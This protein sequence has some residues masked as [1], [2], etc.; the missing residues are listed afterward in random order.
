[1]ANCPS[2][3][4]SQNAAR[5]GSQFDSS[6]TAPAPAERKSVHSSSMLFYLLRFASLDAAPR[7]TPAI[8]LLSATNVPLFKAHCCFLI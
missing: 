4:Q 1:M 8:G 6:A 3:P 2:A 5:G 7:R